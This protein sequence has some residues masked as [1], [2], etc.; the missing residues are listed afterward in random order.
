MACFVVIKIAVAQSYVFVD[1][2]DSFPFLVDRNS[3]LALEYGF[4]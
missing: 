1:L 3:E 4:I 2:S